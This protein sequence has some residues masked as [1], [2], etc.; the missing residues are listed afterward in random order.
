MPHSYITWRGLN[1][2]LTSRVPLTITNSRWVLVVE[3]A[4]TERRFLWI[5]LSLNKL[6]MEIIVTDW[7]LKDLVLNHPFLNWMRN[8]I[9]RDQIINQI[10]KLTAR[11]LI[12]IQKCSQL[13][14]PTL[15]TLTPILKLSYQI[16]IMHT[17]LLCILPNQMAEMKLTY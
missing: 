9:W 13:L 2:F 6:W 8:Q 11:N 12:E 14:S 5:L 3:L 10:I 16:V 4:L 17:T 15:Q 1:S 7:N